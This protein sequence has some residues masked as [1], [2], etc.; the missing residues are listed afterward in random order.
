MGYYVRILTPTERVPSLAR[1]RQHLADMKLAA[2][3]IVESGPDD[4]WIQLS[5]THDD[6][7]PIAT[8]ERDT[9]AR[10][11]LV[12]G[13]VEEFLEE[14]ADAQPASA[15]AWLAEYLPNVKTIY[16]CRLLRGT[17]HL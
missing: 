15:A 4:D 12:A 6:D 2:K 1:L 13:E 14:I 11:D 9:S 3:L 10:G 7:T 5:L 16:A 8:I 17:D